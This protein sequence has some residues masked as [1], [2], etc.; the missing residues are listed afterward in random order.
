M[1]VLIIQGVADNLLVSG[2]ETVIQNDILLLKQKGVEVI[3]KKISIPR[4]GFIS[5]LKKA[6]ALTW[7]FENY[8]KIIKW[9]KNYKPNV[10]HFHSIIPYLSISVLFASKKCQIP[11]VQTLHNG[12]WLC[13]E[14]AYYRNKKYCDDCVGNYGLKG[15]YRSCKSNLFL[16][17][18]LFLNNFI[19]RKTKILFKFVAKF[20]AVSDFVREQHLKSKFPDEKIIVRNNSFFFSK[21]NPNL[22]V[23]KKNGVCF[24]GRI[25][26]AKGS[27]ILHHLVKNVDFEINIIG[28]GPELDLFKNLEKKYSNVKVLGRLNNIDTLR[29]VKASRITI[30]PSQCGDS[31][32]SIAIESLSQG[33]P[34]VAS[35]IGG[36]SKIVKD[37]KAG[38]LVDP[39]DRLAFVDNVKELINDENKLQ[40]MANNGIEYVQKKINSEKQINQL[41][42][43]YE[44]VI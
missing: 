22:L 16:S 30:I 13:I 17:F 21:I 12:R 15:F 39:D 43:I 7:S 6:A 24:A 19:I 35:N 1:R 14:G 32:P 25:S 9:S 33:T 11:V 36:L 42:E 4:S 18:L 31:F 40:I 2:E 20:I 10:I 38:I 28:N 41:I 8:R 29:V 44:E 26:E 3:Y 37:S 27:D 34:I 23:K 5:F